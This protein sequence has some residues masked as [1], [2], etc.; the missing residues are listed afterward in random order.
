MRVFRRHVRHVAN[1]ARVGGACL[2]VLRALSGGMGLARGCG[3]TW[4]RG[5]LVIVKMKYFSRSGGAVH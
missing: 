5:R 3:K 1:D 4:L 2:E